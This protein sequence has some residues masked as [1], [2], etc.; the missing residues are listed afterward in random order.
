MQFV[1]I[2][3]LIV[4]IFAV[5]FALQNPE[6]VTLHFIIWDFHQL[7][8]ISSAGL[9][10]LLTTQKKMNEKGNMKVIGSNEML[11]DIFETTGFP[12]F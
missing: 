8:Y 2:F 4:S 5:M 1:I 7:E 12:N 6:I 11:L 3:A 9:R 10:V